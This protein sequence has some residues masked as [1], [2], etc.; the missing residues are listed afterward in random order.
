MKLTAPQ[1]DT[2]QSIEAELPIPTAAM[3]AA[4]SLTVAERL[5]VRQRRS[6]TQ[7]APD[8]VVASW[9]DEW[10]ARLR[11]AGVLEERLQVLGASESEAVLAAHEH[12]TPEDLLSI[13]PMKPLVA[14]FEDLQKIAD[15]TP[16]I[17]QVMIGGFRLRSA[18]PRG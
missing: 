10:L 11:T 13:I 5:E 17:G 6:A 7:R 8:T 9:S 4:R 12:V 2:T 18:P 14:F 15:V 1:P 3:S 16:D